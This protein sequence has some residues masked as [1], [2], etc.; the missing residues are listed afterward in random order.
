MTPFGPLDP[1]RLRPRVGD[2]RQLA[3]IRRIILDDGPERGVAALLLTTGMLDAMVLI[4]RALDIGTLHFRGLPLA[5]QAPQG[6]R[7]A[8][9]NEAESEA[10]RGLMR[11]ISGFMVTC[12]LDF[13]RQPENGHPLHGRFPFTPARLIGHGAI[14]EGTEPLLWVEGEAVQYRLGF[15]H[16]H[17]HRR[18]EAPIGRARVRITDTVSNRG[19]T[20]IPQLVLYH[21]NLGFPVFDEGTTVMAGGASLSGPKHGAEAKISCVPMPGDGLIGIEAPGAG[22]RIRL[23]A[24]PQTLPWL[25]ILH[26]A[27]PGVGMLAIEPCNSDRTDAAHSVVTPA[28]LLEPGARRRYSLGVEIEQLD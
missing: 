12:G 9:L 23:D 16:L 11:T 25:Q 5:W 1:A 19:A 14:W 6:F 3:D 10:G 2:L 21:L 28:L 17:L 24:S 8:G 18:I 15:E 27:R 22:V 26:D 4:D 20:T 7:A 13:V